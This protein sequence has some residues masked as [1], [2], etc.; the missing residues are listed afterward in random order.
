[1]LLGCLRAR[2]VVVGEDFHFGRHRE[3][4]VALRLPG[5]PLCRRILAAAG[6]ALTGTSANRTGDRQL[7][8]FVRSHS[9][10][11]VLLTLV[12]GATAFA[13]STILASLTPATKLP[14]NT[15]MMVKTPSK[16]FMAK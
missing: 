4:N 13:T 7:R 11:F 15:P 9:R 10:F 14:I 16:A 12:F 5:S 1:M 3:G 8:D 6:G 2:T